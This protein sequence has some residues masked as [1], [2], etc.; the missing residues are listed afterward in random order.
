[1]V[2]ADYLNQKRSFINAIGAK[3]NVRI[4]KL[5]FNK[6]P[7]HVA[8]LFV[9][10]RFVIKEVL[11]Y[12]NPKVNLGGLFL[13]ITHNMANVSCKKRKRVYGNSNYS[14]R[15]LIMIWLNGLTAFSIVPLRIASLTGFFTSIVGIV[16]MIYLVIN[17]L[18]NDGILVG[19]SS[20]MSVVLF[21]GGMLM[22]M[23]G[24]VGEYVG[25]ISI[26]VNNLPLFVIKQKF[27]KDNV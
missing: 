5:I 21:V 20:I 16:F 19:Y 22:M 26:N 6:H 27:N 24:I 17:K 12:K 2:F 7:I 23:I 1:M 18:N 15:K 25:R 10:K 13:T 9:S 8:H 3:I 4:L 11:K 14:L